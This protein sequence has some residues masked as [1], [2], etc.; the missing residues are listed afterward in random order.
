MENVVIVNILPLLITSRR[1]YTKP[2]QETRA[3]QTAENPRIGMRTSGFTF[4]SPCFI[5]LKEPV[6]LSGDY[7]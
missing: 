3:E 7:R 1:A 4:D 6:D 2:I 5:K